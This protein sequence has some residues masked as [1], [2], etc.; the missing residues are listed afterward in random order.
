MAPSACLTQY[1]NT[2]E[3]CGESST[4]PSCY[5]RAGFASKYKSSN[6][7]G[8]DNKHYIKYINVLMIDLK[9]FLC[10]ALLSATW[11]CQLSRCVN[12]NQ[13]FRLN[14]WWQP[15]QLNVTGLSNWNWSTLKSPWVNLIIWSVIQVSPQSARRTRPLWV[16]LPVCWRTWTS[17][18]PF[19]ASMTKTAQVTWTRRVTWWSS[20]SIVQT[21]AGQR[22][23]WVLSSTLV[24]FSGSE[25]RI[26][27]LSVS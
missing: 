12:V 26:P 10:F 20:A 17:T 19:L 6:T 5:C 9:L 8:T 13:K 3:F 27:V 14:G 15:A 24:L 7:L 2:H 11:K 23:R 1:C 22:S 25:Q 16:W 18:T 4:G 21:A